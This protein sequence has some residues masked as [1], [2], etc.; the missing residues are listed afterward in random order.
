MNWNKILSIFLGIFLVLNIGLYSYQAI[1]NRRNYNLSSSRT[2]QLESVMKEKGVTM[3]A[4]LP[5]FYPKARLELKS[6][7][8]KKEEILAKIFEGQ[9]YRS[10]ITYEVAL[11]DTYQND[12]QKLSFYTGE[13]NGTLYYA[14]KNE[15]YRPDGLNLPAMETKAILF[16]KDVVGEDAEFKITN[17]AILGDGY[18]LDVNGS[19]REEIIFSTQ[20]QIK[21]GADGIKEVVGKFYRPI[22]FIGAPQ[23]IYAF[24]EVM[25][26]FMNKMEELGK[27]EIIIKDADVGYWILDATTK[28]L[29]IESI[30]VYRI[31]LEGEDT[32]YYI[33]AYKN[34][35][36]EIN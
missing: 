11:A 32:V 12:E 5:E 22:D 30:P 13:H 14:G 4:H 29:S 6:S 26:H 9:E 34:E 10:E 28:Q 16:A 7:E 1:H 2:R 21:M 17:R 27:T 20:F 25:Y 18:L 36:L 35:F 33:D 3:Y 31:L 8:W 24:D 15:R 19:F 23:E